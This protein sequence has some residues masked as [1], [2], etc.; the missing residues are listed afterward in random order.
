MLWFHVAS[1]S[2]TILYNDIMYIIHHHFLLLLLYSIVF[3]FNSR[4][5]TTLLKQQGMSIYW[6]SSLE[7]LVLKKIEFSGICSSLQRLSSSA[8]SLRG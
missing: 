7:V 1:I 4:K 5:Y 3:I 2:T 8:P 6:G